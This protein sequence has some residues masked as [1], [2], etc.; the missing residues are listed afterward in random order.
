MPH[1]KSFEANDLTNEQ[2]IQ[3]IGLYLGEVLAHYGLWFAET[4]RNVG[5]PNALE[6]ESKAIDKFFPSIGARLYPLFGIPTKDGLPLALLN[7]SRE[8]LLICIGEIAKTWVTGDGLWF[9]EVENVKGMTEAKAI[10]D[11]CWSLFA[12]MEAFKIKK[13]LGLPDN[14]GLEALEA[15]LPLRIYSTINAN[16]SKRDETGALIFTMNECRVQSARRRKG[17]ENYPCKSA[18]LIEYAEFAHAIDPKIKVECV[19]CPPDC[20]SETE[21]CAWRFS[22]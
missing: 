1:G 11:S 5:A 4:A 21:F 22:V 14:G 15:A 9:Q 17:L 13:F 10:N 19:K 6:M 12:K 7:K 8:E 20:V 16:N 3:L 18:G 2:L